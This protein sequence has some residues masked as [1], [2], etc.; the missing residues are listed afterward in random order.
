MEYGPS[1]LNKQ[2]DSCKSTQDRRGVYDNKNVVYAS[3]SAK[4]PGSARRRQANCEKENSHES[5]RYRKRHQAAHAGKSAA[6][7][8][9]GGAC[10]APALSRRQ[11]RAV[12]F[13]PR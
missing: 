4:E 3:T 2:T 1:Y 9:K 6:D 5:H 13:S 11:D 7:H 8:A 12:L 10:H